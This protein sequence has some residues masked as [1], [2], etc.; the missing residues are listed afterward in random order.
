MLT[1]EESRVLAYLRS[2]RTAGVDEILSCGLPG[3]P[4]DLLVRVLAGLEWSGHVIVY[5]DPSGAP[6]GVQITQTGLNAC[7]P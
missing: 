3:V 7:G 5:P 2:R 6:K 1:A 4:L